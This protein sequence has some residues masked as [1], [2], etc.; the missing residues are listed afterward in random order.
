MA[1][2]ESSDVAAA[3]NALVGGGVVA[4]PTETV[5][6]LGADARSAAAVRRIFSIKGRPAGNPLI[7][8]VADETIA[9]RYAAIWPQEA[10]RLARSL[11]P[12]PLTLVLPKTSQIVDEATAGLRTVG[13]RVPN[14]ALALQLLRAFDG[15]LAAPS[16]NR[17]GRVSPTTAEHVRKELGEGVDL[18]LDGGACRVG[19]ESTVLDLSVSVPRILRPGGV[20]RG[21]IEELIGPVQ[22]S[23]PDP[24]PGEAAASPGMQPVHYSPRTPMFR[25]EA[26]QV[27]RLM[28]WRR[29]HRHETAAI[30]AI[31]PEAEPA[32]QANIEWIAMPAAPEDY[33]RSLYAVLHAA[34][35]GGLAAIWVW[36]PPDEPAWAAVRDRLKRASF[37]A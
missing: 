33:A 21:E 20:K 16:A 37:D 34:D 19:I 5:Y 12:G 30:L 25:V 26:D 4:F 24:A 36:M 27:S 14:H 2:R 10:H 3:V 11:W 7:V 28:D 13:L 22:E 23:L 9:R 32:R 8:H 31:G 35:E 1:Q 18:I 17:S 29:R 15:P 6:G